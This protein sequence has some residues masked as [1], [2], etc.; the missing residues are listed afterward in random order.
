MSKEG[1]PRSSLVSNPG[2]P[3]SAKNRTFQRSLISFKPPP[4][5]IF[6][7]WVLS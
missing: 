3:A 5:T 4:T 7:I 1:R 2:S 6:F